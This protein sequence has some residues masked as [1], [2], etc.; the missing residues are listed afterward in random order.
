MNI[1]FD[2]LLRQKGPDAVKDSICVSYSELIRMMY[3]R[4]ESIETLSRCTSYP[5]ETIV[6]VL[7]EKNL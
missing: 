5:K 1:Y 2:N 4:Q 3:S 6:K 7:K